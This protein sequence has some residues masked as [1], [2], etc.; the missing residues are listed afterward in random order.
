MM[1]IPIPQTQEPVLYVYRVASSDMKYIEIN[2]REI[3]L[4]QDPSKG[5]ILRGELPECGQSCHADLS[6]IFLEYAMS[7]RC[8]ENALAM[9]DSVMQFGERLSEKVAAVFLSQYADS[10]AQDIVPIIFDCVLESMGV[11]YQKL[12]TADEYHVAFKD[13]PIGATA[14]KS[15]LQLYVSPACQ[16]FIAFCE[17]IL[18][19]A[20]GAWTMLTP[21]DFNGEDCLQ[22]FRLKRTA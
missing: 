18:E 15:G 12:A 6:E 14:E 19:A 7:C 20:G 11:H 8:Y 9:P 3:Y 10:P 1:I 17:S 13:P 5:S 22:T 4:R 16:G 2:I 21:K